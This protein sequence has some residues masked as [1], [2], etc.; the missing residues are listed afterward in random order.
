M[1]KKMTNCSKN[2]IKNSLRLKIISDCFGNVRFFFL[3]KFQ[4]SNIRHSDI[5]PYTLVFESEVLI[6][7]VLVRK[8]VNHQNPGKECRLKGPN[9]KFPET[10]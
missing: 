1:N 4:F 10:L 2:R 7:L 5:L 6:D 8:K 9:G 3:L